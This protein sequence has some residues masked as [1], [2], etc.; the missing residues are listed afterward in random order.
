MLGHKSYTR[1]ELDHG[2]AAIDQQLAAYKTLVNAIA[3]ATSDK[4]G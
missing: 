1:E 4:N 2:N 3:S